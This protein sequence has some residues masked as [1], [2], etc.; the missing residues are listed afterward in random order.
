MSPFADFLRVL[1]HEGRA[2]LREAPAP[3][4]G[5]DDAAAVLREAYASHRLQ[6]AGPPVALDLE[7]ALAAGALAW[8]ACWFL[9]SHAQPEADL[10]KLL[11]LPG[12]PR[13]PAQHLS[14]DLV[15]R[16]LPA[17]YRRAR[18]LDPADRLPALLADVLRRWPLS[19]VLA[20]VE[21]GPLTPLD[22]GGHPGLLLLYAERLAAHEKPAWVPAG[23]G[24]EYVELVWRDLGRDATGLLAAGRAA[25]AH[26][27]G[28]EGAHA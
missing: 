13:S 25:D 21:E 4:R 26:P 20:D 5:P 1:L 22:F 14:A 18:A 11:I 16:L 2:V 10:E 23:P 6:V 28:G 12:P 9:V 17:V 24:A 19:G 8:Y 15:L 3:Q 27:G 7:T